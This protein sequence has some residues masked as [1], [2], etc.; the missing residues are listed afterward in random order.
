MNHI[1]FFK[2]F[3]EKNRQK[4]NIP[5]DESCSIPLQKNDFKKYFNFIIT[6][7]KKKEKKKDKINE[8]N[9]D[10]KIF[11]ESTANTFQEKLLT[12]DKNSDNNTNIIKTY[13]S[14]KSK[15]VDPILKHGNIYSTRSSS[16]EG[17]KLLKIKE[18][19]NKKGKLYKILFLKKN[20]YKNEKREDVLKENMNSQINDIK[21]KLDEDSLN[22]TKENYNMYNIY[23][24][25]GNE[26][27][28]LDK[29]KVNKHFFYNNMLICSKSLSDEEE[30]L[31]KKY[32]INRNK[33]KN[34]NFSFKKNHKISYWNFINNSKKK[35]D[36]FD[37][38]YER[39]D[40]ISKINEKYNYDKKGKNENIK[41]KIYYKDNMANC[42]LNRNN[43]LII[44]DECLYKHDEDEELRKR[45]L[46]KSV[47]LTNEKKKR[48]KPESFVFLKVIGKG[49]YGKVLLVKHAQ[50]NKLFAMK[51]LRKENII[52][53]NQLEHTKIERNVLKCVSHPFIVKLYYAFQTSKKLY[54]ILEYCPGGELFFH[55]SKLRE[56]SEE[57]AKFYS[58]EIILALQYLHNLNIIYRDLKPE[59]VLL[60]ELGHIRLTDFGLSK[61]GVTDNNSAKS[62]CGTPEYLAPEIIEQRG[63]GKAVD[64]WSLGIMIY[65][66]LTGNL[67][68]NSSN[69]NILF[70]RIKYENLTYPKNISPVAVDLLKKLFEKNPNKRLG[71]GITDAEE[72]KKHPFFKSVNWDD[73]LNKKV[74]PPFKPH[75]FN[76]IDLQNFDKEFLC[77]PLRYSD[78]FDSNPTSSSQKNNIIK[79]F[80]YNNYE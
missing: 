77:M 34:M 21:N 46:R 28:N 49:S 13:Y 52:S 25:K 18:Y 22:D 54:F 7:K 23:V 30:K 2:Y 61:E 17:T 12:Y 53:K 50:N 37:N 33:K 78:Q 62:L 14:E 16:I 45:R 40:N 3:S 67:P 1:N 15:Q 43:K 55:L 80:N 64:W 5:S 11:N 57:V 63:H 56:F 76:Q 60:D 74:K 32:I 47:S 4:N 39:N 10:N 75:L 70:E 29:Y 36:A 79:D 6:K 71:S 38:I 73:V 44:N 35:L 69:R 48:M 51:I 65:E 27:N 42:T 19:K 24:K 20:N 66:M 41:E 58:S 31:N 8:Q 9:N 72:I 68:F 26:L 59:N